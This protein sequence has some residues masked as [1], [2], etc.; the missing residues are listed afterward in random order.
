MQDNRPFDILI[1]IFL[2]GPEILP[3][4]ILIQFVKHHLYDGTTTQLLVQVSLPFRIILSSNRVLEV[5]S[6]ISN[7][8]PNQMK[9]F[10]IISWHRGSQILKSLLTIINLVLDFFNNLGK[11][12]PNVLEEDGRKFLSQGL[13]AQILRIHG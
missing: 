8:I 10:L 11:E 4:E 1:G 6:I 13:C 5:F 3:Y 2:S 12:V 9:L 7:H